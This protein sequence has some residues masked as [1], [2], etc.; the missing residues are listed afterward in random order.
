MLKRSSMLHRST[1]KLAVIGLLLAGC[2]GKSAPPDYGSLRLGPVMP[3]S[4]EEEAAHRTAVAAKKKALDPT[5]EYIWACDAYQEY[6]DVL[7]EG[8]E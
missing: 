6:I 8:K 7:R 5:A 1:F 2:A 3:E 4:V